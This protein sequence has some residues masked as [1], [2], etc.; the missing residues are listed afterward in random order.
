LR[1]VAPRHLGDG[2]RDL[3]RPSAVARLALPAAGL[4]RHVRSGV[5]AALARARV[6][7]QRGAVALTPTTIAV[8]QF[9]TKSQSSRLLYVINRRSPCSPFR[10]RRM[11]PMRASARRANLIAGTQHPS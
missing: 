5:G 7:Y 11:K 10:R 8:A 4:A 2:A 9:A 1:A 6:S 3:L